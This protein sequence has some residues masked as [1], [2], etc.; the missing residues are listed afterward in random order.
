MPYFVR[1]MAERAS[2]WRGRV[3]Y[4]CFSPFLCTG[5]STQQVPERGLSQLWCIHKYSRLLSVK[6]G[7]IAWYYQV[8]TESF[9]ANFPSEFAHCSLAATSLR[10]LWCGHA[11]PG[12]TSRPTLQ[13][14]QRLV[15]S[16]NFNISIIPLHFVSFFLCLLRPQVNLSPK[17]RLW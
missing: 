14:K 10:E 4:P 11:A 9:F 3:T 1:F 7:W 13:N 12:V 2:P 16:H 6:Y 17:S 15:S 5:G 8:C